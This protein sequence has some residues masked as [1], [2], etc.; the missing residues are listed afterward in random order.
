MRFFPEESFV[1]HLLQPKLK[2]QVVGILG[3]GQLAMMLAKGASDLGLRPVA[4]AE[5]HR[6]PVA[7]SEAEL[8]IGSTS[9]KADLEKLFTK[10]SLVAYENEFMDESLLAQALGEDP[11]K[12][13]PSPHV[14]TRVANKLEQKQLLQDLGIASAPYVLVDAKL[15]AEPTCQDLRARFPQGFVLKLAKGGYDG[16]GNLL[17]P[18]ISG[19]LTEN[20]ASVA[21]I[22]AFLAMASQIGSPVYAEEC[23]DFKTELALVCAYSIFGQSHYFPLVESRQL[24]GVCFQVRGPYQ[25]I[26]GVADQLQSSARNVATKLAQAIGLVGVFAIEFFLTQDNRLLVNEIAP[27]VHNSAHYSQISM[28]PDQFQAHWLAILGQPFEISPIYAHYAMLNLL[29]PK[30]YSGP[31]DPPDFSSLQIEAKELVWYHKD[32]SQAMRKLGHFNLASNDDKLLT[33]NL[34]LAGEIIREWQ[35]KWG[36]TPI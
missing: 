31:I 11:S 23:I 1:K 20:E 16:K 28:S 34:T 3:G 27:R 15:P 32:H 21:K 19:R 9:H 5:N 30:G 6:Q 17:V 8:L 4:L 29:G 13:L 12:L 24:E 10:A 18:N 35:K 7:H 25:A 36:E 33:A 14:M 2:D 26:D 22:S